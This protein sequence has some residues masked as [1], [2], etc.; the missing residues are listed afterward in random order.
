VGAA[1]GSLGYAQSSGVNGLSNGYLG[2]GLDEFGNYSNPNQSRIGGPGLVPEAVAV[3][4]P[5]TGMTNYTYLSGTTK[6]TLT[7]WFL[8][9]LDCPQNYTGFTNIG[10][11]SG[12]CG[13]DGVTRPGSATYYRQVQITV[14]P[15]GSDYQVTVAMKFGPSDT[16]RTLFGP[17]TVPTSAPGTLKMGFAGSTGGNTN[18][19]EIRNLSVTQQVPDLTASKA[20][21][22]ATTGGGSVAPGEQLLYTVVL[23]NNTGTAITGV[24]FTD[25]IPANTAY[26]ANSASVPSGST[27]TATSPTLDI[28]GITVPAN[29]QATVTFKVQVAYP[30]P[31][32]V[33]QISN[34]GAF[35]YG[36]TTSQTDGDAVTDGNQAT[37]IGV[38]AGPNFDTAT[39]T[40]SMYTD[41]SPLGNVSPGDTLLYHVIVPNTG[42][43]NSP[44]TTFTDV[45]PGNTTYVTGSATASQGTAGYNSTTRTLSWTM[46]VNAGS[47][48]T[49]DFKVTVNSGVQIRDVISNQGTVTY[50][51]TSVLTDADLATPGK[52]PTQ[53]LVGGVATLTATKTAAVAGGGSLQPDGQVDYTIQL[54]NTGSYTVSSATFV[55]TL[56]ANTTYISS[57]TTVG[58]AT[59]SSPTLN[60][61]GISLANGAT[62]T[63]HLV[64]QLNGSLPTGVTQI[65]NQ[66]VVNWDSNNSGA[67]NTSLQTDGD[68]AT[69]GQQ[70]TITL[71]ANADLAVTKSVNNNNPV[72]AGTIVYTVGVTNNGPVPAASVA[73]ADTLPG[74]LT[75]VSFSATQGSYTSPTWTVGTLASGASAT[76]TINARVN[77]GQGGATITNTAS[78]SSA[79]YDA[80]AAN[81]TTGTSLTVKATVLTGVVTDQATGARLASVNVKVA[82]SQG[83]ISTATTDASGVYSVT[84]GQGGC[85]LAPGGTTVETTSAPAGYL[86]KSASTTITAGVT[87]SQDLALFRPSLSGVVTEL[88]N[89]VPIVDATVTFTQGSTTCMTTTGAG[90]AYTFIT[91][92]GS[93]C[94]LA[95]GAAKVTAT[96]ARYQDASATPTILSTGPTSQDLYMGT[97]DLLITKSDS[98]TT[99][100]PGETLSYVLTVV[101][102]GSIAAASV[103]LDDIFP[104]YL[105]Y[106]SDDSGITKTESP[107]GTYHWTLGSSLA[108]G[109]SWSFTVQARVASALPDGTTTISN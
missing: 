94:L 23:K 56:P 43:Q 29:G 60:V 103:I 70:P 2:L 66:G 7:P 61:T 25:A 21:Q 4:G 87:N 95:A 8:P 15:V 22:N 16:F 109:A 58:T 96:V 72:E 74:G 90:G 55:D 11:T 76:L 19:H 53:L 67:N 99:V 31:D 17:F 86:M 92:G 68:P 28:T 20:V 97:A 51:A 104:S 36:S 79:I 10:V 54:T 1:G 9:K 73:V 14:T 37:V 46:S 77:L 41:T 102:N 18:Y 75:F 44:T 42:N 85:L 49:L 59:F 107:S 62:A 12:V 50:G 71:I 38:T 93:A 98:K 40:V 26:V 6:L 30:I 89:G 52:Q 48:A 78:A 32:G 88:V 47:Q 45:L 65:S 91:T 33:T 64:V 34:Q 39:K 80:S 100:K 63:I 105:T 108:P 106:V 83:H 81:N 82:D 3:R 84:S 5:G 57:S 35:T 27:L 24:H 69:A 101:N 13:T